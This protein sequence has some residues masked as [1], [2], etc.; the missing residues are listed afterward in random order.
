[1]RLCV[2]VYIYK[3][4]HETYV[5]FHLTFLCTCENE[6]EQFTCVYGLFSPRLMNDKQ[7]GK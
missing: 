3:S 5:L 6:M 2:F 7:V 4:T 1:M